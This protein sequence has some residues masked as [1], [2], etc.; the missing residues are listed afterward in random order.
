MERLEV[1]TKHSGLHRRIFLEIDRTYRVVPLNERKTKNRNRECIL[2]DIVSVSVEHPE[3]KV[4]KIRFMD[5]NRI[6]RAAL[7][8]LLPV[9]E[10]YDGEYTEDDLTHRPED[11]GWDNLDAPEEVLQDMVYRAMH[12][13]EL[14]DEQRELI[15]SKYPGRTSQWKVVAYVPSNPKK[16]TREQLQAMFGG[17]ERS[18]LASDWFQHELTLLGIQKLLDEGQTEYVN[19]DDSRVSLQDLMDIVR[20]QRDKASTKLASYDRESRSKKRTD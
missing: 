10:L 18:A 1:K 13:I 19:E 5:N 17:P 7:G 2:V 16:T 3:D 4:A 15:A 9:G 20:P 11:Y 6:G 8:D 14:T 12:A